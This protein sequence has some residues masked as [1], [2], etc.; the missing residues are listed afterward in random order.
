MRRIARGELIGNTVI[1]TM[2][3]DPNRTSTGKIINETRNTFVVQ[4]G[5]RKRRV[6][7]DQNTIHFPADNCTIEGSLLVGR[8]E[9]RI[10]K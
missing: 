1:V 8:P 9:E 6:I 7:K 10:K 3:H 5:A 4:D 2:A